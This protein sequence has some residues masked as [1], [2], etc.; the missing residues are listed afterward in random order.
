MR[1]L[2]RLLRSGSAGAPF[3][4]WYIKQVKGLSQVHPKGTCVSNIDYLRLAVLLVLGLAA[5]GFT[6]WLARL[7][8]AVILAAGLHWLATLSWSWSLQ[9]ALAA[10]LV[11]PT[12][13]Y[14]L[15]KNF[16]ALLLF[17]VVFGLPS[18]LILRLEVQTELYL[19]VAQAV[20]I[21][22]L[23]PTAILRIVTITGFAASL[24]RRFS[25]KA[26]R[27][28]FPGLWH[29][30]ENDPAVEKSID[31]QLQLF[32]KVKGHPNL[33]SEINR[34]PRLARILKWHPDLLAAIEQSE[35][36]LRV[37]ASNPEVIERIGWYPLLIKIVG[38]HPAIVE[39]FRKKPDFLS[40]LRTDSALA[41]M[42]DRHGDIIPLLTGNLELVDDLM[43]YCADIR[44]AAQHL[45]PIFGSSLYSS[46]DPGELLDSKRALSSTRSVTS[47]LESKSC[48]PGTLLKNTPSHPGLDK[49]LSSYAT[50]IAQNTWARRERHVVASGAPERATSSSPVMGAPST[51]SRW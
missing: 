33:L 30:I 23:L 36:L 41:K 44:E 13:L 48:M 9:A 45:R 25:V 8:L 43:A 46:P 6:E 14:L 49:A 34:D 18:F 7:A 32:N 17:S 16:Q 20:S 31:S 28:Q 42:I 3:G 11:L 15:I 39:V 26:I 24:G 10:A 19:G 5:M 2:A 22:V 37:S 50:D 40:M 12:L 1:H 38:G 29:A 47:Y 4:L 51:R 27:K 21:T 35:T